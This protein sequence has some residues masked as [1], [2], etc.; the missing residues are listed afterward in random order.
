MPRTLLLA[1]ADPANPYGAALAWP[2]DEARHQRVPS[3]AAGAYVVLHDGESVLYLERGGKS[4]LTFAPF[5]DEAIAAAPS[6]P[7]GACSTMAAQAAAARA[8]RRCVHRRVD[9]RTRL[10]NLAFA[11]PIAAMSSAPQAC[12][13]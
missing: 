10:W 2:R 11:K 5:D 1:A 8:R 13:A 4:L 9:H 12:R 6:R 3:R 7:C